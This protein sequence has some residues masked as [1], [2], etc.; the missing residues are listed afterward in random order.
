MARQ[1]KSHQLA[2]GETFCPADIAGYVREFRAIHGD[3]ARYLSTDMRE[4]LVDSW[5]LRQLVLRGHE[6]SQAAVREVHSKMYDALFPA[7]A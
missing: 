2:P 1:S 6:L 7:R 3:A 5:I 4:S